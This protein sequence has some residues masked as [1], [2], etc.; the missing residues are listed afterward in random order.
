M[1]LD[2]FGVLQKTQIGCD[3]LYIVGIGLFGN[4]LNQLIRFLL[5]AIDDESLLRWIQAIINAIADPS[6]SNDQ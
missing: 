4:L 1:P 6:Q 3:S 2:V 5:S